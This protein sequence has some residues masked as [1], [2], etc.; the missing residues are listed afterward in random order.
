MYPLVYHKNLTIEKWSKYSAG[1]Q[2][3]MI[4]NE[5]NRAKNR[6]K[7]GNT[8]EVN[9]C[10]ERAMEL[11]DLTSSDPKWKSGL[12]ELRRFRETLGWI[13]ISEKK[14]LKMNFL[15]YRTLIQLRS[16][17]WNL[18]GGSDASD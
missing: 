8:E 3:L 7:H 4:A 10:Y 5:L 2:I 17:S 14:D 18:L 12:K 9:L 1:R 11:T 15:I 6:I 16:E 13:Y